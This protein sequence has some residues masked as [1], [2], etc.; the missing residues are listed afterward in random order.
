MWRL[1]T[2]LFP[3]WWS[4]CCC[5]QKNSYILH[6]KIV[7]SHSTR[8]EC[9][10]F[11][12]KRMYYKKKVEDR[13]MERI[14]TQISQNNSNSSYFYPLFISQVTRHLEMASYMIT[15]KHLECSHIWHTCQPRL[16]CATKTFKSHPIPTIYSCGT[17]TFL[18]CNYADD[19]IRHSHKSNK[20][21]QY[22]LL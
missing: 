9:D 17:P 1:P 20:I 19:C 6:T 3:I 16:C 22:T 13:G 7:G 15:L 14:N 11:V 8:I 10:F 21:P 12:I 5:G 4:S 18:K 2:S